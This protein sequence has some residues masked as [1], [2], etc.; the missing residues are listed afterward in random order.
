LV[1]L[2]LN[3]L[4]PTKK[5]LKS[6]HLLAPNNNKKKNKNPS[7]IPAAGNLDYSLE[8]LLMKD[9]YLVKIDILLES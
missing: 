5:I 2:Y 3:T 4:L 1:V 8:I 9:L 7:L 6:S